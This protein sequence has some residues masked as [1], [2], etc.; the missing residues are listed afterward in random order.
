M[1]GPCI[2]LAR[3]VFGVGRPPDFAERS[4]W[5]AFTALQFTDFA[6]IEIRSAD[7][8]TELFREFLFLMSWT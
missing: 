6:K 1:H 7:N 3:R 4:R 5:V 8:A 2:L